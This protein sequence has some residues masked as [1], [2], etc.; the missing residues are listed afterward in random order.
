MIN[1]IKSYQQSF[2]RKA[3]ASRYEDESSAVDYGIHICVSHFNRKITPRPTRVG[4]LSLNS[5]T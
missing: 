3:E 4:S 2:S 1:G 5:I